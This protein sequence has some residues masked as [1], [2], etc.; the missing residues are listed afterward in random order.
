MSKSLTKRKIIEKLIVYIAVVSFTLLYLFPLIVMLLTSVKPLSE[1]VSGNILAL[2]KEPTIEPWLTAWS[3]ACVGVECVGL[4]GFYF[5]TIAIAVP[6][7]VISTIVGAVNGYAL[8]QFAFP[9]QRLV[10]GLILFGAFTPYQAILIP[11][12]Q[13]LGNLGLSGSLVGLSL[14]HAVYGIPFTTAFARGFFIGIPSDL[15]K[16]ARI[17]GA[18]FWRIFFSILLPIS[19]PILAVS[20]IFQFTNI[21]NDFLFGSS[22]TFGRDA[23]IMVALNNIVNTSTGERPY[24]VHMAAALF[25][26]MPTLALYIF[27]GKYFIRGLTLGSVKG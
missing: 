8:T 10:Y 12:A 19:L 23:P 1:I 18:G 17:D 20:V 21:W 2:P 3:S 5:N 25:A 24:N 27:A 14:T 9:Y 11:L 13:T 15:V 4:R 6:A 7:V 26:A 16:A 22:L